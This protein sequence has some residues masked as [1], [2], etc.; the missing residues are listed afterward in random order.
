VI[1]TQP[2]IHGA[3]AVIGLSGRFPKSP[4]IERYWGNL[5][6]GNPCV[7]FFSDEELRSAGVP[8]AILSN[9][10][11]VKAS[12]FLEQADLFDAEF[13]NFT[14]REAEI[15]DPQ[16][17]L[18]LECAWEALELAGYDPAACSQKIG[19]FGGCSFNSYLITNLLPNE[20]LRKAMD[21]AQ[22][23]L[24]NDKD[25]L[26]TKVSYKLN[27]TGP[28]VTIQ[29]S[30][31][32]SLVCVHFA[33]Q[34]LLNHECDIALAGGASIRVGQNQG[35]LYETGSITSPDGYCRAFDVQAQGTVT[36]NGVGLV[37]LKRFEEALLDRDTIYA[38]IRGSA[39]NNDGAAKVGYTAPSEK[40]QAEVIAEA[41]AVAN[42][43]PHDISYV[44]AHGTGTKLG[45][46]IEVAALNQVFGKS[47]A[48]RQVCPMGSVKPSI[49]HLDAA[50][51]IAGLIKLILAL[52]HR[53]VPPSIHFQKQNPEI[54][55]EN[56]P[57][58]VSSRTS[59]W[60]HAI[61]PRR[62]SVSAFGVGGTNAHVV[63]EE[64]PCVE[65]SPPSSG[66]YLLLMSARTS[67]AL[68]Q[69]CRDLAEYLTHHPEIDLADIAYTRAT[70]RRHF[71]ER[72]AICCAGREEA[73]HCLQSHSGGDGTNVHEEGDKGVMFAFSLGLKFP[74]AM[75]SGLY[76]HET[77]FRG[78]VEPYLG[79]LANYAGNVSFDLNRG[80]DFPAAL[81]LFEWAL[82]QTLI[83]WGLRPAAVAG[84]RLGVYVAACLAGAFTVEE[85]FCLTAHT[86]ALQS[87]TSDR[88]PHITPRRLQIPYFSTAT[89][90]WMKPGD[91]PSLQDWNNWAYQREDHHGDWRKAIIEGGYS[92][93]AFG[94]QEN[95]DTGRR[96][97][98]DI[99]PMLVGGDSRPAAALQVLSQGLGDLWATG[100]NID[101]QKYY[102]GKKRIRVPLPT[103]PFE[104]RSYWINGSIQ[105]AQESRYS[106]GDGVES[107]RTKSEE[108][109]LE[110]L[111]KK[112]SGVWYELLGIEAGPDDDFFDIGGD[113]LIGGRMIA[114]LNRMLQIDLSSSIIFEASTIR[115]LTLLIEEALITEIQ[116]QQSK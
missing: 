45:D 112:V 22:L 1:P 29:T 84:D 83:D 114:K 111:Q 43:R 86:T 85:G 56:T 35:Y 115:Q 105:G 21:P 32:S 93:A 40:G 96:R 103:Y 100:F 79:T 75:G 51:G 64:A 99:I 34:S 60:D 15:T 13:F 20:E 107:D 17:R 59:N 9:P 25:H 74:M 113:S 28:S 2:D 106:E 54:N 62:G 109:Q 7:T 31:S 26:C 71:A 88:F 10:S 58:Y 23:L 87:A 78:H 70:G 3:I 97:C 39:V 72:R 50:A 77:T 46:P 8:D 108:E 80:A 98:H 91:C 18:F 53:V 42:L 36:G 95:D 49:G 27:L 57:F 37:A 4:N 47:F 73:L 101:W 69:S 66:P 102:S 90:V 81:F 89:Q 12:G 6:R 16:H 61:Y 116:Q 82:A 30:C 41:L 110:I 55:F 76:A 92:V 68:E 14:P 104:K 33:C 11:Y 63:M 5:E 94:S 67:T 19:I 48:R 52:K 65:P 38:V 44:E 24:F